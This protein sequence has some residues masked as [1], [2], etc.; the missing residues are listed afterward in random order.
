MQGGREMT[1]IYCRMDCKHKS[2]LTGACLKNK[3]VILKFRRCLDF[4]RIKQKRDK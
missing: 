2:P 3:I 1:D 4:E